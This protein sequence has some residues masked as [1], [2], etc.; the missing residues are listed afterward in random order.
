MAYSK[1]EKRTAQIA[2]KIIEEQGY[3]MYD[4][5]YV[6]EGPYWFLRIYIDRDEGVSVDDCEVISNKVS[7]ILDQEDFI[8]NNYILEVSSPGIDRKLTHSWHFDKYKGSEVIVKTHNKNYQGTLVS[9]DGQQLILKDP[10]QVIIMK[11]DI[12]DVRLNPMF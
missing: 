12:K 10:D 9:F 11:E 3:I 2:E 6:K 5:E 1:I 8:K 7:T 4:I